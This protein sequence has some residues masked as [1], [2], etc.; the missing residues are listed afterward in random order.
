MTKTKLLYRDTEHQKIAG[1]CA[2]LADY[3][4]IDVTLIRVIWVILVLCAGVG[5]IPYLVMALVV[6]PKHVVV[7]RQAEKETVVNDDP[8]AKYDKK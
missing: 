6:E 2:G 5:L 4:D 8:F 1:V 7:Q 3:L